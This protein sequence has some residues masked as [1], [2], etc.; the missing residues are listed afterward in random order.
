MVWLIKTDQF[1]F[2]KEKLG[3]SHLKGI[4]EYLNSIVRKSCVS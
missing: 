4:N 1:P 2:N 3:S